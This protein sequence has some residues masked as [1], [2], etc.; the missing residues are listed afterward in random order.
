MDPKRGYDRKRLE[1]RYCDQ[2]KRWILLFHT[3]ITDIFQE[4]Q[5]HIMGAVADFGTG[6]FWST[7]RRF[8]PT[9]DAH[10]VQRLL[11]DI[12]GLSTP[13]FI[14]LDTFKDVNVSMGI[15]PVTLC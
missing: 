14:D 15:L 5:K 10:S 11:K 2:E 1:Y 8:E 6:A 9:E 13:R 3:N 12:N 4:E 7:D